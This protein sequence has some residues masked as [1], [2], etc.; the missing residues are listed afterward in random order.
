MKG[1][2]QKKGK[3]YYAVIALNGKRKWFKGGKRKDAERVLAEKLTEINQGTYREIPKQTFKEFS[4]VWITSYAEINLKPSTLALYNIIL[5]KHLIP[6]WG[7]Y[8]LEGIK[9]AQIQMYASERL[10]KVSS[11]TVRNEIAL[12]ME[13]DV[14]TCPSMGIRQSKSGGTCTKTEN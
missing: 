8:Q 6:Q 7:D 13:A 10:K 1:S 5:D 9:A 14:Q 11:K 3:T 12:L 4:K 2:I